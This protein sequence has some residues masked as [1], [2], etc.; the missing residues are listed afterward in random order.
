MSYCAVLVRYLL[1]R[2]CLILLFW[3]DICKR[4]YVLLCCF[5]KIFVGDIMS[6]FGDHVLCSGKIFVGDIM[7][8][9]DVL[10]RY[11]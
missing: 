2:A 11:L 8:Y 7:S 5:G 3:F 1:E 10:V 4:E 9:F 6:Y